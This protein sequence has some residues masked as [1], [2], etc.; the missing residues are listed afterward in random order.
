MCEYRSIGLHCQRWW[1]PYRTWSRFTV[2]IEQLKHSSE[3][4]P[5][6]GMVHGSGQHVAQQASDLSCVVLLQLIIIIPPESGSDRNRNSGR[7][8]D[9]FYQ[10]CDVAE[11]SGLA[12]RLLQSRPATRSCVVSLWRRQDVLPLSVQKW[13]LSKRNLNLTLTR[14][15]FLQ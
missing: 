14:D 11:C 3:L 10:K 6:A 12:T 4:C 7:S 1:Y 8:I 2:T 13:S 9:W 15:P 5:R